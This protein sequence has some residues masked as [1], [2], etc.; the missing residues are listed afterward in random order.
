MAQML[1]NPTLLKQSLTPENLRMM[2]QLQQSGLLN[3]MN[4]GMG[5]GQFGSDA[6]ILT[7]E[8]I[9]QKYANEI[10]QIEAMGFTVDDN[11]LQTLERFKG[12]VEMTLNFLLQ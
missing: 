1:T 8:Q 3:G 4:P 12:N 9:R 11:V 5:L 7:S 10:T 2:H 6:P